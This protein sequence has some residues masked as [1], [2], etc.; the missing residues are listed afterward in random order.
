MTLII[1]SDVD[2]DILLFC[3]FRYALG[4]Q[5]YVVG[6][7]AKIL[8]DNWS[9]LSKDRRVFYKKEIRE[10]VEMGFAGSP[11]IDVPEWKSILELPD[12]EKGLSAKERGMLEKSMK[13][14][15]KALKP[16]AEK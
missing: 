10:A 4:R 16:L 6:S 5:T 14:H 3:A 1:R 12:D 8:R 15:D 7:I 13:R 2:Q 11:V 9:G